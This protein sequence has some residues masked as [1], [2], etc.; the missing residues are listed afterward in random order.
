MKPSLFNA[1][2]I[3]LHSRSIMPTCLAMSLFCS[4][5]FSKSA[6]RIFCLIVRSILIYG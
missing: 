6:I 3:W 5:L 2:I 4:G 1:L